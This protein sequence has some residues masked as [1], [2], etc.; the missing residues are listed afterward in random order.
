MEYAR[1]SLSAF[2]PSGV[3]LGMPAVT[4]RVMRER[5][6]KDIA[7]RIAQVL[8]EVASYAMPGDREA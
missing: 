5:E 2:C 6:M 3:H 4:T 1:V 8:E 7:R